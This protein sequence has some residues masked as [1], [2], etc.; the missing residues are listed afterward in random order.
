MKQF[1]KLGSVVLMLLALASPAIGSEASAVTLKVSPGKLSSLPDNYVD[2]LCRAATL[3]WATVSSKENADA[4]TMVCEVSM[5]RRKA[6][7]KEPVL[8]ESFR[9]SK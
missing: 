4:L 8:P 2:D 5:A 7:G 9:L 6:A 1:C 3:I